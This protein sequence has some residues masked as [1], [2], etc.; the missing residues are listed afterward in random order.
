[1][2]RRIFSYALLVMKIL[3]IGL[4][5]LRIGG[6]V[7]SAQHETASSTS[8]TS[9]TAT[10]SA[11]VA[12]TTREYPYIEVVNSCG[13]YYQGTCVNLRAGPGTEYPIVAHLRRGIVLKVGATVVGSDGQ[14]WYEIAQDESV[15]YPERITSD[16]YV[17]A[18]VVHLFYD[19]GDHRLLSGQK[20]KT[21]KRIVVSLSKFTL[22]AYEGDTLF[23][24][25]PI[26]PGLELTPTPK[27]TFTIFK[28]TP[29][30]YMQGPIPEVSDQ[31]YDLPGV[32]WNL[33]FTKDGAVIHGAYWHDHFGEPW[34]HGCINLSPDNAKKLYSWAEIGIPVTVTR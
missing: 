18:R 15:R 1:M 9:S 33:Y 27:G 30:R 4:I 19:D 28:M 13:P 16:W 17:A 32:P 24:E 25:V 22:D 12:T 10:S 8:A 26:S 20:V 5:G 34:S 23:M 11:A 14:D 6:A 31:Y 21:E 29:S 7:R 2:E 3:A